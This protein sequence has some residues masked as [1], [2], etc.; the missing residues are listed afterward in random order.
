MGMK[1]ILVTGSN[2]L[3][4]QKLVH[5]I[6]DL[7]GKQ[8]KHISKSRTKTKMANLL[9]KTSFSKNRKINIKST[10][11]NTTQQQSM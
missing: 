11:N 5:L 4:G 6:L 3:L 10:L 1:K 8:I 7:F 9:R 2:G